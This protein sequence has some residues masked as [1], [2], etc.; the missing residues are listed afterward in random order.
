MVS[1]VS[2]IEV[3]S[4]T[5]RRP[6]R[7]RR[8][9]AVLRLRVERAVER[10]DVDRG[11][12][13][14]LLEQRLGA[15]DFR[16][17][18][19][20]HQQRARLGAQR[21]RDRVGHLPLDRRARIAAE[22]ARLDR[23]GAALAFDHR[24]VAQKLRHP[25][26]VERRRH[27]QELADPRA[28]PAAR[29]AP[30]PGR[31][32]RRASARGIRRTARRR[33]R[34]ATGSSRISRVKMPSVTTSMRVLRDTFEPKRTRRPTVSPTL[35]AERRRHALGGGARGEPA[36]LQHQDFLVRRP[37]LVEQHQRHARGLAGAGRRDQHGGIAAA[38][39]PRSARGS[40]SS[41]GS[42]VSNRRHRAIWM[43]RFR[44][45]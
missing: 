35:L 19:Q 13:D 40:A 26:A 25:R 14:A 17:A 33:R 38:A 36:R 3:A 23:K 6:G 28:G 8:D 43:P 31:D 24:R 10:H 27:H 16:R 34:R 9:G 1:E 11:I 42:A 41:I 29:R 39:A 20:E 32:R 44:G 15:A 18:G 45:A 2:A 12:A 22:I 30:A 5:L 37:R 21:A 7:R 4:T